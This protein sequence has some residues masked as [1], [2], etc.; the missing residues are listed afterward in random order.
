MTMR[1]NGHQAQ[2]IRMSCQCI[3]T[4]GCRLLESHFGDK[5]H[6]NFPSFSHIEMTKNWRKLNIRIPFVPSFVDGKPQQIR[7]KFEPLQ[8]HPAQSG[9]SPLMI[10]GPWPCR[11]SHPW[12]RA[13]H[14]PHRQGH[15][16]FVPGSSGILQQCH[17]PSIPS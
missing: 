9:P 17:R 14:V 10:A 1:N 4:V 11:P 7:K 2:L 16:T 3:E 13:M 8:S 5:A 15:H 6:H 12:P